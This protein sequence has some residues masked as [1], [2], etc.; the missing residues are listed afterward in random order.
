MLLLEANGG[1]THI[2]D[3]SDMNRLIK[4]STFLTHICHV[5]ANLYKYTILGE[6][7]Y[8]LTVMILKI[9]LGIFFTRIVIKPWQLWTIYLSMAIN[10]VAST[11]A[12]CYVLLRCGPNLDVYIYRQLANHCMPRTVDRVF[13]YTQASITT[14]TDWVFAILPIFVLWNAH[15]DIRSKLS[16]GLILSLAGL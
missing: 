16:V 9:S 11:A 15:M 13:A 14:V 5:V 10:T 6:A 2:T 3:I 12:L 1:G 8:L 7:T 4:V